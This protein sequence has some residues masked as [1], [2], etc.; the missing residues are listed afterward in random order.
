MTQ[1]LIRTYITCRYCD[2][3]W[4]ITPLCCLHYWED[5]LHPVSAVNLVSWVSS[6]SRA[7]GLFA[8]VSFVSV[9]PM[10][11]SEYWKPLEKIFRKRLFPRFLKNDEIYK[12]IFSPA[13]SNI[14]KEPLLVQK[15]TLHQQKALDISFNLAPWK[16][17][18]HYQEGATPPRREKNFLLIFYRCAEGFWLFAFYGIATPSW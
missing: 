9:L 1:Y 11:L 7:Q 12:N 16:W 15:Q 3:F 8:E 13:F 17:A 14:L 4:V 18:W 10:V 5:S 6:N 2:P